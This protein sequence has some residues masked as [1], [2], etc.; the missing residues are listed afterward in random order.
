MN[1]RLIARTIGSILII[2]GFC[3][4]P[5][6]IVAIYF[7]DDE[8]LCGLLITAFFM[9]TIG[10]ALKTI[11]KKNDQI[12]TRDGYLLVVSTW[13]L[14]CLFSAM[15]YIIS[16]A[17]PNFCDA[18]F[19]ACSG[20]TTTGSSVLTDIEA[21]PEAMLFWRGF[22]HWMGGLGILSLAIAILP[23][24]GI[25][26]FQMAKAE[27]SNSNLDKTA[28]KMTDMAKVLYKTYF[29]LTFVCLI[30]LMAGGMGFLDACAN[31]FSAIATGGFSNKNAS[32]GYF[33]ST[34]VEVVLSIFMVIGSISF[35]VIYSAFTRRRFKVFFQNEEVK[36]FL[37]MLVSG[38]TLV[39]L[40]LYCSGFYNDFSYSFREGFFHTISVMTT[41]GFS[42][43]DYNIWPSATI[44]ILLFLVFCGGCSGST[45]GGTKVIRILILFKMIIRE[46][47][48]KLH[49][50]AVYSIKVKHETTDY[51]T[52]ITATTYLI[53][54][55]ILTLISTILVSF[56][57]GVDL[58][59]AFSAA[60]ASLTNLGPGFSMVGPIS[61]FGFLEGATKLWLSFTMIVGKLEIF[62]VLML[63]TPAFWNPDR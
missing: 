54:L 31:G 37:I 27:A 48:R 33:N 32:I 28:P 44:I 24:L 13:I 9:W 46:F 45:A 23:A 35:P 47:K 62:A 10:L 5:S 2:V 50:K 4:I 11:E 59:T 63:F 36:C 42:T 49:P 21:L 20:V 29:A 53:I 26:G 19:E 1:Y 15:P 56:N 41:T 22:T 55:F 43:S 3:I 58:M 51:D 40:I 17:I 61:N 52:A 6:A 39:S 8:S 7:K 12:R 34:Y 60:F 25:G 18:V 30:L 38:A 16:G 14:V 57:P